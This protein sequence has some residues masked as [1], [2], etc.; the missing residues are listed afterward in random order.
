MVVLD[1]A[2]R[3]PRELASAILSSPAVSA[4]TWIR[5]ANRLIAAMPRQT[6]DILIACETSG[7]VAKPDCDAATH[8]FYREHLNRYEPPAEVEAYRNAMPES[9]NPKIY[10]EM[11]GPE[12]F[13][14]TGTL[15]NFDLTNCLSRIDGSRTLFIAGQFDEA[16]PSSVAGYARRA[17]ASF[18]EI[19]NAGHL[20]LNDN[21]L[22]Y[23]TI[24]RRWLRSR[25]S[26]AI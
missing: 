11:W 23:L 2:S 25:D 14:A 1:Y 24:L 26:K 19:P 10:N 20:A 9:F 7:K 17:K 8:A 22:A 18:G 4:R 15:K 16:V 6:R 13:R 21:P 3:R 5:D 12:E